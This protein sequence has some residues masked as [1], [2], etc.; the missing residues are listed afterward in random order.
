M[1]I[2]YSNP[3]LAL[4]GEEMSTLNRATEILSSI[5]NKIDNY[6]ECE[7]QCP[8]YQYCPY[9]QDFT[10]QE[11]GKLH[12]LFNNIVFEAEEEEE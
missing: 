7:H 3:V 8:I 1:K 5:C 11:T 10:T 4:T 6:N 12:D 2:V 9:H